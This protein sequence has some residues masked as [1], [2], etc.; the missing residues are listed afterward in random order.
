MIAHRLTRRTAFRVAAAF[1]GLFSLTM[2][3]V[4]AILYLVISTDLTATLKDQ[5]DDL[6][7]TFVEVGAT[8]GR[9]ALSAMVTRHTNVNPFDENVILLTDLDGNY[10]AGNILAIPRFHSWRAIPWPDLP[11]VRTW[12]MPTS[13]TAALG[14]WTNVKDGYLFVAGGN[15]DINDVQAIL[16]DGL[17]WAVG[18]TAFSA[19]LGGLVLGL[20]AQR[21]V[22]AGGA[23]RSHA[24]ADDV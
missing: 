8:S 19:V 13:S 1:A 12:T 11:F 18:L 5:I 4:F 20:S 6:R 3:S 23:G 14:N 21:R 2:S 24:A 15:G 16:L 22:D 10:I 9:N 17:G 7:E